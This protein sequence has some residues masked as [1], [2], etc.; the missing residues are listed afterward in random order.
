MSRL[1]SPRLS[2]YCTLSGALLV[3]ALA[4][5]RPELVALAAPFLVFLAIALAGSHE[6]DLSVAVAV[7]RERVLEGESIPLAASVT[8]GA[9]GADVEL[10][11]SLPAG[12]DPQDAAEKPPAW[13][14]RLGAHEQRTLELEL[15]AGRWGTYRL[16]PGT[17]RAWDRFGLLAWEAPIEPVALARVYP[18]PQRLR[19]LVSPRD[20][21]MLVGSRVA[22]S[23]G[24]GVEFADIRPF[25]AGDRVRRVNWRATARRGTLHVNEQHP[26]R[27]ADVILFLDTFEDLRSG[28]AG[29]LD[30]VLR[31]AVSLAAG[32][33]ERRDRVGVVGFGGVLQWLEPSLGERALYR[34][35][36]ALLQTEVVFSYVWRTV[37]V[38]PARL[39]P[40][41]SLVIALTPLLDPRAS[42]ALLDL[43]ARGYDLSIIECSPEPFL[44]QPATPQA[45]LARRLWQLQRTALRTRLRELGVP[46]AQ[47]SI[48]QPLPAALAEVITSRHH[49]H[50]T[51]HA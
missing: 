18:R 45:E 4:S 22:R 13:R 14:F 5:G 19:A 41:G 34:I 1:A 24:E 42:Q 38:I 32:Y 20:T 6:P 3:A 10:A 39:L 27:N 29:T 46:V 25:V 47:W 40:A 26:E 9:I 50:R 37:S 8:A 48:D 44:P 35:A 21:Q 7:A 16:A 23:R 28:E 12:I 43:R 33:L 49:A 51:M 30:L 31:G 15:S 17:V 11:L 2:A 36:D